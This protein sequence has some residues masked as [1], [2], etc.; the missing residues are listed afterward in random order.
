MYLANTTGSHKQ[1]FVFA[2]K[3]PYVCG[4]PA[5]DDYC[6]P[7]QN[8]NMMVAPAPALFHSKCAAVIRRLV[9]R[10]ASVLSLV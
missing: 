3:Q 6:P 7:Q 2:C 9:Y 8:N 10:A 1:V 4:G 5:T